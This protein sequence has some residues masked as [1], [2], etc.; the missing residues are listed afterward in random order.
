[1][2]PTRAELKAQLLAQAELLIDELLDWNERTP[3]P[4]LTQ[5]EEVILT[6]RKRLGGQMATVVIAAQEAT[7]PHP[8][9]QCP[10]CGGA[11]HAKGKKANTV[12]SRVGSLQ[13]E[14]GYYYCP[15]CQGGVFPP[16]CPTGPLGQALE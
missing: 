14:R 3:Q 16:G 4:T 1:M 10:T 13:M 15:P 6:L 2:K 7:R 12:E 11:M 5:I 9:P 8:H